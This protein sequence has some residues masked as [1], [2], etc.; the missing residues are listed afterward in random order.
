M[1]PP[2]CILV[3][4][5]EPDILRFIQVNL[6]RYG[7]V[8]ETAD[9]GVR[10]LARLRVCCPDILV[11]DVMMP[12]M[13]G[14]ELLDA[15]RQDG[16]LRDVP[17]ILMTGKTSSI[18]GLRPFGP[19]GPDMYLTKPFNPAELIAFIKRLLPSFDPPVLLLP[20]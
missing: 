15:I 19:S 10:A 2:P 13:D 11:A 4:D 7:C 5:D 3:V 1:T 20:N 14:Y 18:D 8:V 16:A 17:V 12:E 6:E 9:S